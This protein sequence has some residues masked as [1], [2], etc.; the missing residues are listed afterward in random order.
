M[1]NLSIQDQGVCGLNV[2]YF[3]PQDPYNTANC[4]PHYS[5]IE[6]RSPYPG[7]A[8][9]GYAVPGIFVDITAIPGY[10]TPGRAIPGS[11][12]TVNLNPAFNITDTGFH[13]ETKSP[14]LI[15]K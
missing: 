13:P 10:A 9:P 8:T 4:N 11:L 3:D 6:G 5:T 7:F 1:P 15:D 2:G 12:Y 14:L